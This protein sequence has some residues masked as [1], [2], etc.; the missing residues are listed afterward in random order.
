MDVQNQDSESSQKNSQKIPISVVCL[1][2]VDS[3]DS[4]LITQ[5]P[6]KKQLGGL[7]EFPG[8]KIEAGESEEA[9]LRRELLEELQLEVALLYP[10]LPVTHIYEFGTI[11]LIPFLSRCVNRPAVHLM[12]HSD[13]AWVGYVDLLKYK[14]APADLPIVEELM[15]IL[16]GNE[17]LPSHPSNS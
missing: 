8:G 16:G 2:L 7:W 12:E 1:V 6:I 15:A 10:L 4:V 3:S 11:Q 9:A 17:M 14:W 5:R 13:L